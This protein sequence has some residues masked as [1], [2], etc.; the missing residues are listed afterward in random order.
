MDKLTVLQYEKP[1][2]DAYAEATRLIIENL[3]R[4]IA[5]GK[6]WGTAAWEM[7][8]LKEMG[9]LTRENAQ[10]LSKA[11]KRVPADTLNAMNA[12]SR[13]AYTQIILGLGEAIT[14]TPD[15]RPPEDINKQYIEYWMQTA[16][17]KFNLT[18]T[19]MLQSA[20]QVYLTAINGALRYTGGY[21]TD[22]QEK[23]AYGALNAGTAGIL[24]GAVTLQ[25]AKKKVI[26][27]LANEGIYGFVD[28]AGRHW[29]PEAYTSMVMRTTVHNV[30]IQATK[31]TSEEFGVDVFQCS[32][33]PNSRPSHYDYQGKFYSWSD[34]S[35]A[36][37]DGLGE[38]HYYAPIS[39]TGY[40]DAGGLFGINC[41]HEAFPMSEGV[42]V[43]FDPSE[44]QPKT[45]SDKG[46]AEAQKQRAIERAI[47]DAKT[48]AE[49]YKT[50]GDDAKAAEWAA[51]VKERQAYM[52]EF[53]KETGRTRSYSR[54]QIITGGKTGTTG[55]S[56]Q[57][58]ETV[59]TKAVTKQTVTRRQGPPKLP[60]FI[61][62]KTIAEAENA[63]RGIVDTNYNWGIGVSYEGVSVEV[64]NEVNRTLIGLYNLYNVEKIGGIK[65]PAGN[66]KDG[67]RIAGAVAA[68]SPPRK[69]FYLN[70]KSL[71][72][73]KIAE[74]TLSKNTEAVRK[75]IEHP[76]Q[77]HT[78]N[79]SRTIREI[80]DV[81][82]KSGRTSVPDTIEEAITHEFG[83]YIT[84]FLKKT[85]GWGE[86]KAK[87]ADFAPAVSAYAATDFDEYIAESFASYRKGETRTDPK[88][89][90][91]FEG[92]ER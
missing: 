69:S 18:N 75:V 76:E 28:R 52:R 80:I 46:Y 48:K 62:A 60:D 47:R 7:Q 43:P 50:A 39:E 11:L 51:K 92:L 42:S 2:A 74:E 21:L 25:Q 41:G 8:K 13:E 20:Q 66:T 70:R 53:L 83:H 91:L 82:P 54:E 37:T 87:W 29:T 86:V 77:Y 26:T 63:L 33:H 73:A 9:L 64:A 84:H 4:H 24:T 32:W 16:L 12:A 14:K 19:T 27:D 56:T 15:A 45:E 40:G 34:R 36:F 68:F 85:D 1:V 72:S 59:E 81:F 17:D 79:F 71:K 6:A 58:A 61:P 89:V 10:I 57:K 55:A 78:E 35:G 23:A 22:E 65:A 38:R 88:L 67:K 31:A 44:I 5:S 90:E 49:V 30:S 3:A